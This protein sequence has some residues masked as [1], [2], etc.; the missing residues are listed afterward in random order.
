MRLDL[1]LVNNHDIKSRSKAQALIKSGNVMVN[2]KIIMKSGYDITDIDEVSIIDDNILKYVSRGGLK[3]EKAIMY[4]NLDFAGKVILDIGSSTGGF[5]DCSLQYGAERVI[6]VDVGNNIMESRLA[7]DSRVKLFENTDIRDFQLHKDDN[8]DYVVCDVSFISLLNIASVLSSMD[9]T[10]KF[11]LLIKPQFECGIQVAKKYKG[12]ID[13]KYVHMDIVDKLIENMK[14]NKLY[15]NK[16]HYSPICGGDGNIEYISLFSLKEDEYSY[17][18]D[19]VKNIINEAFERKKL[20][21][22]V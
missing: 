20:H 15:I 7:N 4:F 2:S 18:K 1:Y 3:L 14:N 9:E 17:D 5:T 6:A 10:V 16:L 8:I 13:D 19:E 11:V 21:Q 22:I 12:I